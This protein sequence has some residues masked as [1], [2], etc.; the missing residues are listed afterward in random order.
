VEMQ[1]YGRK[2]P[3][4]RMLATGAVL[5]SLAGF[6][7]MGSTASAATWPPAVSV[8]GSAG[9][10]TLTVSGAVPA[11]C[12]KNGSYVRVTVSPG[13][14]SAQDNG[15][16]ANG[17]AFSV[18]FTGLATDGP[19]ALTAQVVG[20]TPQC[21]GVI[22]LS[23]DTAPE[24]TD[25]VVAGT[26]TI[27]T[28]F[29]DGVAASGSPAPTYSVTAG[30]LPA[31]LTLDATTGAISG[32]PTA[33]GDHSFTI[34]AANSA[35]SISEDF[36]LTVSAALVAPAWTDDSVAGTGTIG[37]AYSDGVA[38]SGNPAPT[39]AVVTGAL[40]DGLSLDPTSG[41][42]TGTP[43]AAGAHDFTIRAT[44]SEGSVDRDVTITVSA[45]PVA[46]VAPTWS[47]SV[48]GG[49]ATAGSPY[50]DLVAA[51]GNPAPTYAVTAGALPPGLA[52]DPVTGA[53]TGTPTVAGVYQF[54]VTATNSEGSVDE[55]MTVEVLS[56]AVTPTD[57]TDP[58]DPVDPV[59][60]IDPVDPTDPVP[61]VKTVTETPGPVTLPDLAKSPVA[62]PTAAVQNA[63]DTRT[64]PAA[65]AATGTEANVLATWAAAMLALGLA[66]VAAERRRSIRA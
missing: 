1:R 5:A 22:N 33:A 53:I 26:G 30:A 34:T 45:A 60:P 59:D 3:L 23:V 58:V 2:K 15:I 44:N 7:V 42:I 27:G 32:T 24:W 37:S 49:T 4:R 51:G 56:A 64:A 62:A 57:P 29:A 31:G 6:L 46:L 54:T 55:P 35:G 43:T 36:V 18:Q 41:A 63:L 10:Y 21:P 50:S 20:G 11:N 17:G 9:A 47:D 38:A 12:S 16:F 14:L 40:P 65:L 39:Y 28:A 19:Y 25:A 8:G 52:L 66:L 61:P 48:V 13:G